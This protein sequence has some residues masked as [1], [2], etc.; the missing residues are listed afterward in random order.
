[1]YSSRLDSQPVRRDIIDELEEYDN[2]KF[3]LDESVALRRFE[4][5]TSVIELIGNR[6]YQPGAIIPIKRVS[7]LWKI[8][9]LKNV[10]RGAWR[11][12]LAKILGI[13]HSYG[14]LYLK[15]LKSDGSIIDYG[16]VSLRVVTNSGVNAIVDAFQGTFTLNNFKFHGI[17]TGAA[18]EAA[19][20]SALGAELTTQ[21]NP[22]S[23]RATGTTTEGASTNI[24]RSI[25]T[26]TVDA[27][28]TI[29]EHGIFSQSATGGGSM[30]DRSVFGGIA[31]ASG[32]SI[33]STYELT[34][35]AGS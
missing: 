24:F 30:L 16:L 32:D 35:P 23:V 22:D 21:Y 25:G 10:W 9:N 4:M 7:L 31:L 8:K 3:A 14:A 33:Q 27:A 28:V 12:A 13:G 6:A 2:A 15:V 19:T 1:M 20:D 26:N 34:F 5:S 17:G 18:A 11:I 29:T